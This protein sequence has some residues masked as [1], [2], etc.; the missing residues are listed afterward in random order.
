MSKHIG[1]FLA[2]A[3]ALVIAG[4]AWPADAT[5]QQDQNPAASSAPQQPAPP[6]APSSSSAPQPLG[7]QLQQPAQPSSPAQAP[8]PQPPQ[9]S[10]P[11]AIAPQPSVPRFFVGPPVVQLQYGGQYLWDPVTGALVWVAPPVPIS[12]PYF[13]PY[14]VY[15][16]PYWLGPS[17]GP[18]TF[19]PNPG[20][21]QTITGML[22]SQPHIKQTFPPGV[23]PQF[24]WLPRG[25]AREGRAA[26]R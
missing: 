26:G 23:G 22:F 7:V 10:Q 8:S 1:P 3:L 25:P 18:W 20:Y 19:T 5:G 16:Y 21:D 11:P 2:L 4:V 13:Y 6:P 12:P 24:P 14:G 9:V 15:L 17:Q